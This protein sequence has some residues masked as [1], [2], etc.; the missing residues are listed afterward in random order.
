VRRVGLALLLLV[1][2]ALALRAEG[3][4][5]LDIGRAMELARSGSDEVRAKEAAAEAA[6]RAVDVARA[7]F[8][9]KLSA[10]ISGSWLANPPAGVTVAAGSLATVPL[11]LPATD[12]VI[13]ADAKAS[14][15]KG[16]LTFT[17]PLYAWGKIRAAVDLAALEA[18][19]ASIGSRGAAQ[20]AA[21]SANRA[22][23][24]AVL[25]RDGAGILEELRGLAASIL[26]DMKSA[27]A[28]GFATREQVLSSAADLAALETRLVQAREGEASAVEALG[29]L[30]GL[31]GS[32]LTLVSPF[33]EELPPLDEAILRDEALAASAEL[34]TARA[35][36]AQAG[37]KLELERGSSL[38]LPD[39]ALFASLDLAGQDIPFARRSWMDTWNWDLSLGLSAKADLFDGGA[40]GARRREAAA[41]LEA[42]GIAAGAAEKAARLQAR[43]AVDA[44]RGAQAALREKEAKA[45][46]AAEALRN[47]RAKAA[48]QVASR[49]ELNASAI[50]EASARL[51]LL[52]AR[53]ALEEAL[54]DLERIAGRALPAGEA[55]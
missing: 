29:L 42:A 43:R 19:V 30:T 21:R 52:A 4:L 24:S 9:P 1:V 51:D 22:Y 6:L 18:R 26:E 25:S 40:S 54:A 13:V 32:A 46:W 35:R 7:N 31:D 2:C 20:D 53:Y 12:L 5:A 33:R 41:S 3:P 17:Q 8:L 37:K 36:L 39:L 10:S 45:A 50:G 55:R 38:F 14:Y 49:P 34:D 27:L 44:A 16:N 15:F 48:G 23:Y 11:S 28:E 47:A